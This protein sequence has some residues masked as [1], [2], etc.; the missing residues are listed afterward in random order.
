MP[1]AAPRRRHHARV[2][3]VPGDQGL[4]AAPSALK[5]QVWD[6]YFLLLPEFAWQVLRGRGEGLRLTLS[7]RELQLPGVRE[8]HTGNRPQSW[9]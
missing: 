2:R 5:G 9:P 4:A 8:G 1:G 7:S 3:E 6:S